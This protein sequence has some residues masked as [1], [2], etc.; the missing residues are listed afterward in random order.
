MTTTVQRAHAIRTFPDWQNVPA[1]IRL[2]HVRWTDAVQASKDAWNLDR[3]DLRADYRPAVGCA[4]SATRPLAAEGWTIRFTIHDDPE[5]YDM[6]DLEGEPPPYV[7][8][9]EAT[10]YD[11]SGRSVASE[12]LWSIGTDEWDDTYIW[13]CLF[14]VADEACSAAHVNFTPDP[15]GPDQ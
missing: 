5:P 10:I 7:Y 2:Q 1:S 4:E 6:G 14:D 3:Y 9:V 15:E 8:G 13:S 11:P 12:S